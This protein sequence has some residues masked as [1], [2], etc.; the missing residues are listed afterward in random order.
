MRFDSE[1]PEPG[2]AGCRRGSIMKK[3]LTAKTLF[4]L[5]VM[6]MMAGATDVLAQKRK[7]VLKR[8]PVAKKTVKPAVPAEKLYTVVSGTTVHVRLNSQLSSKV[9]HV[10]DT[11]R[12]TVT[13]PVYSDTGVIVIPSGST[14]TGRVDNVSPAAKGGNVGSIGVTFVSV[15]LPN[16]RKRTIN[17]SLSELDTNTAKSDNEGNASGD[18]TNHRKIKF[19][20]GGG[21]GGAVLGGAIGGGKGAL[22]GG[23]IGG[24]GGYIAQSQTKGEEATVKAGTEF[25]VYLN[26]AVSLPRFAEVTP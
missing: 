15:N 4:A 22:I 5:L 7:P 11:F 16:G 20:G 14:M 8:K 24:V 2:K 9:N 12:V 25:G 26:Q 3:I 21:V 13:E 17:G 6:I 23:I 18:K 19:I 1:A 10:G